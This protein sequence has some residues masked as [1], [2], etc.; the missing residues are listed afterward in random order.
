MTRAFLPDPLPPK[1]IET[2]IDLARRAPSAGNTAAL[3]WLVLDTPEDLTNYW[4]TT[5][6]PARRKTFAWP[7]LLHAP[8]IVICWVDPERYLDRYREADKAH[9]TLGDSLDAWPVPYWFVDGGAA[10]QTLLLAAQ[11]A[12]LGALFFG[13]FNHESE[14]RKRFGVPPRQKAIGAVAL[15]Y[16]STS[17]PSSSQKR[18]RKNLHELIHRGKWQTSDTRR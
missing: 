9:L 6:S 16:R 4:D 12:G 8:A 2:L 11:D 18:Q 15:G 17:K 13:L 3:E 7:E 5:L 14:V 1:L 10:V